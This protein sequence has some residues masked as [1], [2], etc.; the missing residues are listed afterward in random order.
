MQKVAV[1]LIN[2]KDYAERFLSECRD[3]LRI[4]SYL[5]EDFTVYIIDNAS[6]ENSLKY[7]KESYPEAKVFPRND[8]NYSAANNLGI[9]K[10]IE[11]GFELFVIANMDTKFDQNW[12]KELVS[13]AQSDEKIGL[14]QSLILLYP[15]NEKEKNNPRINSLG[16][17]LHYLGF[18]FT[19]GYGRTLKG[20]FDATSTYATATADEQGD[21]NEVEDIKGYASGCSLIIK[22]EVLDKIGFYNE[23]YYM[24]HDDIELGWRAKLAGYKIALA[25]R[26]IVYHKYEFSRSVR[27]F[28]YMERNRYLVMLHFYQVPTLILLLPIIMIMDMGIWFFSVLNGQAATKLKVCQYFLKLDTWSKI[29]AIRREVKKFRSLKDIE[30]INNCV[31]EILFQEVAS[32]ALKYIGNPLCRLY[33]RMVKKLISW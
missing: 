1:I 10:A 25:P 22:K 19:D 14:A 30:I 20:P 24:Y 2:Y 28:Y 5:K 18:G 16:N 3:S 26:S 11:D 13:A 15:K 6:N 27:M 31:A 8:G 7:L 33:F 17:S 9:K 21:K 23:E 29:K 32:P 12:L 4:Q